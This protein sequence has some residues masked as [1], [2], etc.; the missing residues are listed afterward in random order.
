MRAF[1]LR[2]LFHL[3]FTLIAV[4][5]LIYTTEK[6]IRNKADFEIPGSPEYLVV[7]H[8]HPEYLFNDS[9]ID[10][11]KNFGH[12]GETYFY[13]YLKLKQLINQNKRVKFVLV[14]FTNGN[15]E[16]DMDHQIWDD[17]HIGFRYP[18][19]APFM[20][21]NDKQ[22]LLSNN[23]SG[24]INSNSVSLRDGLTN[25]IRKN[26]YHFLP[27]IG[28]YA[29]VT[30]NKTDS[31]VYA[32]TKNKSRK[33]KAIISEN[34]LAYLSKIVQFLKSRGIKV[35]FVRSPQHPLYPVRNNELV[36]QEYRK[37]KF[38]DID[39]W[40]FNNFPLDADEYADLEHVNYKGSIKFSNWFRTMML[41]KDL[42]GDIISKAINQALA[43]SRD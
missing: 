34:N 41:Q 8:S 32:V 1:I 19:Y 7:G 37:T 33:G 4:L 40:D 12:S 10:N 23:I 9:I 39:F 26:S 25:R 5:L 17:S 38:S 21:L 30:Y 13:T 27:D 42:N 29:P 18:L 36:Y 22:L 43:E 16:K 3:V 2:I 35:I 14:E 28:G 15:I 24:F 20:D 11:L 31:L 6:T